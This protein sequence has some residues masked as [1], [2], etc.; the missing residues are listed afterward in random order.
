MKKNTTLFLIA[1]LIIAQI[2]SFIKI[3]NLESQLESTKIQMDRLSSGIRNDMNAIYTNVDEMLKEKASLIESATTKLGEIN[4]HEQT[5]PLTFTLIP[6]EVS[7]NTAVSLDLDGMLYA[8][9]RSGTTF[10]VTL[11]RSIFGSALPKIIIY[12]N[13][14]T[15]TTQSDQIG[16]RSIKDASFPRLYPRLMGEAGFD[17][18]T[19]RRMGQLNVDTVTI[20]SGITF[21]EIHF[22]IKVDDKVISDEMISAETLANGY[23]VNEKIALDN[24]QTCTMEVI[25]IDSLG[26]EHH[27]IVDRWVAG[28][29][30]QIE[31]G[32]DNEQIYAAD[33]KLLWSSEDDNM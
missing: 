14:V 2:T 27:F 12:D 10:T 30:N 1:I 9:D 5:V 23:Q 18:Q 4:V 6:K 29:D 28:S 33:G 26:F 22:M 3:S 7:K 15:K 21:S 19:Y 17:G 8:M 24:G 25:A 31:Y 32:Y 20:D 16:V 13:G 11:S